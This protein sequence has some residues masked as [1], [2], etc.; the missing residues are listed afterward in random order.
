MKNNTNIEEEAFIK[1]DQ[2]I[3]K[4]PITRFITNLGHKTC[5]KL[6]KNKNCPV[7]DLGCG[8]GDHFPYIQNQQIIGLDISQK[9]LS[10][11]QKK[12]PH[13]QLINGNIFNP[14]FKKESIKSI[15]SFAVLEH[16][17]P[18]EKAL[19]QINHVLSK[20]GEFI[21]A[22]PTEGFLYRLGRKLTTQRYIEK[23]T[24]IDYEKLLK[25]EHVNQCV[26]VLKCVKRYFYLKQLRGVPFFIPNINLNFVIVG[27]CLKKK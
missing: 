3:Y 18:L 11:A 5:T 27:R 22:I 7:L 10:Q 26:D 15:I 8:A 17:S 20:D 21:F 9:L 16:L 6:R 19:E 1:T 12:Y 13:A 4:N 14:P 24:G 23:T 2:Y 25:K